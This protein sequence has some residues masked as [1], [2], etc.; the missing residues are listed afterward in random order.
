MSPYT[1]MEH[2]YQHLAVAAIGNPKLNIELKIEWERVE[3]V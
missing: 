3:E 1:K 2:S